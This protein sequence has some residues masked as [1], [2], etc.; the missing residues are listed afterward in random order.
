LPDRLPEPCG[1][2]ATGQKKTVFPNILS[3]AFIRACLGVALRRRMHSRFKHY[4]GRAIGL[5]FRMKQG[6]VL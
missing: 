4:S 5:I 3:S 6:I 2:A 1:I